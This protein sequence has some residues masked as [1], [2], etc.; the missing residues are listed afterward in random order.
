MQGPNLY[1][2]ANNSP[3][4]LRDRLGLDWSENAW[5]VGAWLIMRASSVTGPPQV[6]L[7]LLTEE[8]PAAR[9]ASEEAVEELELA[10]EEELPEVVEGIEGV[11][12]TAEEVG[13]FGID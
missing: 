10:A 12:G 6:D 13:G 1:S 5:A 3:V 8:N 4:N 9:E 7:D 11:A 2:Y